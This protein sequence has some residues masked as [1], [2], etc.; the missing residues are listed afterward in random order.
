[1]KTDNFFKAWCGMRWKLLGALAMLASL[2]PASAHAGYW[3]YGSHSTPQGTRAYQLWVPTG[4]VQGSA[5]PMVVALHPCGL[6]PSAWAGLTRINT[7]ADSQK[8]LVLYPRQSA[9]IN[10]SGCWN[11]FLSTNQARGYGEPAI[12]KSMV[13]LI[14]SHYSVNSKKVYVFGLSAGAAMTSTMLACYSDVFAA[15]GIGAGFMYKAATNPAEAA[16]LSN[17]SHHSPTQRGFDAWN[18]SGKPK[19]RR[20]GVIV[21]QGTSDNL[22]TPINATQLVTQFA[23][24]NDYSDDGASNNSVKDVATSTSTGSA[25]G[26][27]YTLRN[28]NY[29]GKNIINYYSINGLGHT[30]S[31][32]NQTYSPTESTA[33]PDAT[34]IMWNFFKQHSL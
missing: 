16:A 10:P 8:F 30:W 25:G 22:V 3:V 14:K 28:Y 20:T 18:C 15:G 23:K 12:V 2:L 27:S 21:F 17:G 1:M 7:L 4:Y 26:R 19:P 24:T 5:V 33:G 13:D 29:G 11:W 31:G 32:G 6:V 9:A 34:T